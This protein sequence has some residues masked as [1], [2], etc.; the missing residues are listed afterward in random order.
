MGNVGTVGNVG[1]KKSKKKGK[2]TATAT[3]DSPSDGPVI[4]L[5]TGN[6][7]GGWNNYQPSS[8]YQRLE[9]EVT[10]AL[11]EELVRVC[12]RFDCDCFVKQWSCNIAGV[13]LN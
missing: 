1:D 10:A 4:D 11:Y 5:T 13:S 3:P 8:T 2:K 6:A 7:G 12:L 9:R